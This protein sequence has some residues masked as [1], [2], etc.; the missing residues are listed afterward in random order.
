MMRTAALG[1]ILLACCA[2]GDSDPD[3]DQVSSPSPPAWTR[4]AAFA[5]QFYPGGADEL[6]VAVDGYLAMTDAE[7]GEGRIISAVVPHAGY[8]FSAPAAAEVYA[9]LSGDSLD[10]VY[11]LAPAHSYPLRG[12]SVLDADSCATP[13]GSVP[14]ARAAARR[15]AEAHPAAELGRD[16]HVREHSIEVQLPFLKRVL[17]GDFSVVP[18]LIGGCPTDD[19]AFLAELMY[20]EGADRR[21]LVLASSDLS[22]YPTAEVAETVDSGTVESYLEGDPEEFASFTAGASRPGVSTLACG[23]LPM[24]AALYYNRLHRGWSSRLLELSNSADRGGDPGRT[25]GYAAI[26]T[27]VPPGDSGD[28][29][30][31]QTRQR[32]CEMARA[33]LE[34]AAADEPP[35]EYEPADP[36]LQLPRGAFVTY[37]RGGELRGCIGSIRPVQPLGEAVARMARQAADEDPRFPP[38]SRDEL[39]EI[40]LEISVLSPLRL[41]EDTSQ[42]EVGEDGLYLIQGGRSGVLLPQVPVEQGWDRREYVR[43]LAMKAGLP[44]DGYDPDR[45]LLFRFGAQVFSPGAQ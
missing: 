10:L 5:G 30:S 27:T 17:P 41:V 32:L 18:V 22:H 8:R 12:I 44:P 40:R 43:N 11:I 20:A 38:I 21:V 19:L 16:P 7:V 33:E 13:L 3:P 26:V 4:P 28:E 31:A 2:G 39:E 1:L 45:A 34:R 42:V 14:V 6:A 23:R 15:L 29:I 24:T 36:E 35:G 25:V 37:R 9:A